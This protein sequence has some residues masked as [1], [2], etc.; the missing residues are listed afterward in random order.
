MKFLLLAAVLVLVGPP[1]ARQIL[2][3]TGIPVS[4]RPQNCSSPLNKDTDAGTV[5]V[6]CPGT[7]L[8]NRG[9]VTLCNSN[10]NTGSPTVKIRI[11]G[12]APVMGLGNPGDV[13]AVGSCVSYNITSGI[14]PQCIASAGGTHVTSLECQ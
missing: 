13:L 5:V 2:N 10:E 9:F 1:I 11:D 4:T 6:N 7:Q 14:V 3:A 12:T 8:T